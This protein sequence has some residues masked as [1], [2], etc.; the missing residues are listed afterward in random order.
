[1]RCHYC[2]VSPSSDTMSVSTARKAVDL[3]FKPGGNQLGFI[4]FGGEPLLCRDLIKE[5]VWYS[6][7]CAKKTEH[8]RPVYEITTNGLLLDG[9]FLDYAA[10]HKILINFS[11]DGIDKAHD[12]HRKKAN[13]EP[14]HKEVMDAAK[15]LLAAQPYSPVLMT[16]NPDT[17]KYFHESVEYLY[18]AGFRYINCSLNYAADWDGKSLK[19]LKR[20]YNK[21]AVFYYDRTMKKENFYLSPFESKISSH[22]HNK[23]YCRKRC[24]LG[25]RQLSVAPDG[26]IYPCIQFVGDD[27]YKI[28]DVYS[29]INE[30]SRRKLYLQ[31]E[32]EKPGCGVCAIMTRC[33]HY[34]ACLN[35]QAAG[36]IDAVSEILCSH[37]RIILPI[38]DRVAAKL[39][40]KRNPTFL[41]KYYN[42]LYP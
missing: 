11:L 3:A 22:V 36:S 9:A 32:T 2:Y 39:Y 38:A 20:Q 8:I 35:K 21:L 10:E 27:R 23:T 17:V 34:C 25:R 31:N 13:G 26:A 24:E 41:Q 29:G 6:A 5:I 42:G 28:G 18:S 19:E 7:E 30:E 40:K 37:E 4:F 16:V 15:R 1:M 14:T 33:N 12:S